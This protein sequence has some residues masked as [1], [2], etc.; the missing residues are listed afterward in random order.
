MGKR[1]L[2][3]NGLS[4]ILPK[5]RPVFK[6][7]P[8]RPPTD[9]EKAL[10][11]LIDQGYADGVPV[12]TRNNIPMTTRMPPAK[13]VW[14]VQDRIKDVIDRPAR[15][16]Q[17]KPLDEHDPW[18]SERNKVRREFLKLVYLA[19]ENRLQQQDAKKL[20]AESRK[21]DADAKKVYE[22]LDASRLTLPTIDSY[23]AGP[24]MRRRTPQEREQLKAQRKL[25]RLNTEAAHRARRANK[26]LELYHAALNFITTE[27]EL[28]QA[29]E[30]AFQVNF[31][32]HDSIRYSVEDRLR[33]EVMPGSKEKIEQ[34]VVDHVRGEVNGQ[35]GVDVVRSTL[36]GELERLRR[37][38][39]V[40][41][42]ENNV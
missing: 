8:I 4:G 15:A 39:T 28:D 10:E 35:P 3:Y 18:G 34:M 37:E 26:L 31:S 23:L 7:H 25:N 40:R 17:R 30:E 12:P 29:I 6:R 32:K 42:N 24:I 14:T 11:A 2:K 9:A 33:M 36:S 41:V 38:A 20:E 22:E 1:T 16:E 13:R 19:E 5:V 21:Q 27:V